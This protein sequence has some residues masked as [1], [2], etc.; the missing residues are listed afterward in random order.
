VVPNVRG[1]APECSARRLSQLADE[2]GN[3]A[4]P[5]TDFRGW[6]PTLG[7]KSLKCSLGEP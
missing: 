3:L 4:L 5:V 6:C 7:G 2:T 1:R